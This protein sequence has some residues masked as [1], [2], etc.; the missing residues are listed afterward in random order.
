[1]GTAA[2]KYKRTHTNTQHI[3][4]M[5]LGGKVAVGLIRDTLNSLLNYQVLGFLPE[6]EIFTLLPSTA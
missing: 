6:P 4:G 1:M 5:T 3:Q 2:G